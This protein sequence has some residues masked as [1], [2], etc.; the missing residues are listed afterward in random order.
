MVLKNVGS[1]KASD[2]NARITFPE[3]LFIYGHEASQQLPDST[4]PNDLP[5]NPLTLAIKDYKRRQKEK[6]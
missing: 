3:K 6:K 2:V 5:V 4:P 1:Q